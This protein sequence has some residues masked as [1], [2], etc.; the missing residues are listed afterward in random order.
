MTSIRMSEKYVDLYRQWKKSDAIVVVGFGFNS[1]D[2][3]INGIL[4]TLVN[5]DGK[6]INIVKLSKNRQNDIS[7]KEQIKR[8]LSTQLKISDN[9]KLN[10][11]LVD[12]KG[13]CGD[14][15]WINEILNH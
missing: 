10:I 15:N 1:D 2:E 5:E 6:E 9:S 7:E 8:D 11:I 13:Q 14:T 4:R 3:H 12:E